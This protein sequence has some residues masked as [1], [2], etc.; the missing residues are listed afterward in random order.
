MPDTADL[1]IRN[2][3]IVDGSG[4]PA[5]R[6]GLAV[7]GGRILAVGDL[8]E[9]AGAQEID[10][11]GHVLCPGFIDVHT[12]AENIVYHAKAENF[13]R[14]GVTTLVLGNCGSSKLDIGQFFDRMSQFGFSP[15]IASLIGHGTVRNQV[16]GSSMRRPPT[17]EELKHMQQLITKAMEDGALGMST[18]LIYLPGTFAKTDELIALAKTVSKHENCTMFEFTSTKV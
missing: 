9:V 18:G 3:T 4:G 11:G 1:V 17:K 2:A 14:M 6:G 10:A 5:M 15:N 16:M 13:L 8:P 7:A 12:H